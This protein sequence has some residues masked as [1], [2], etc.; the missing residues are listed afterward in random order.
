MRTLLVIGKVWPEPTASAAGSRILQLIEAFKNDDWK[1]TLG[2]AA[3]R[4]E[5]HYPLSKLGVEEVE[6]E[7]NNSSFDD[8]IERLNPNAVMFDR[9]MT[10]EQFGW[11][12]AKFCPDAMRILDTEDLHCLRSA[13]KKALDGNRTFSPT[14]LLIEE[15]AKRELASIYRCDLSLIISEVEINL[16]KTVFKVDHR[17]LHLV[18]FMVES[19]TE[20]EIESHPSYEERDHF[21]TIGNFL[22]EPNWDSIKYLKTEIWPHIRAELPKA[23]MH[24]YGSYS[25]EKNHQLNDSKTGFLI[26]G[27]AESSSH[28]LSNARVCLAPLRY[29]AGLKGKLLEAMQFGTPSVTTSIGA[30]SMHG[31]LPWPGSIQEDP[32]EIAKAAFELHSSEDAWAKAQVKG[33]EIVNTQYSKK[34]HSTALIL[35]VN[36][37][38]VSLE[39]HRKA[40]FIGSMMQYHLLRSTEFMSRW[41][42]AK[43]TGK[44]EN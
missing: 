1:I 36:D 19:I 20:S 3:K 9:F 29:G 10:E 14:E 23:E 24:V 2:C 25:T 33:V 30:E 38:Y 18:P 7:L 8:F 11:R 40:N 43:N 5:H 41:I 27:F 35:K 39:S 16:L 22:H 21:V 17:L 15:S 13:R 44:G 28:V 4:P 32:E 6:I 34:S 26:K 37:V 31:N 12:V 42:E